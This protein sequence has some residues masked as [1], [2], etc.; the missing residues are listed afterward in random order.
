MSY[1]TI[2]R[3]VFSRILEE[4]QPVA[5]PSPVVSV[6][7]RC[8][9]RSAA[10]SLDRDLL[11]RGTL[12]VGATGTGK[13]TAINEIGA[14]IR[15]QLGPNSNM[16]IVDTKNDYLPKLRRPG[17]CILCQGRNRSSS[18]RWN[19]FR[20]LTYDGWD[21][22]TVK[23]NCMEFSRQLFADKKGQNQQ[24]FPDAAQLLLYQVLVHYI[25]RGRES[26]KARRQLSNAGLKRFF[27]GFT[28]EQY[29][30][31]LEE[32]EEAGS[33]RMMLGETLDNP[34]ALGVLGEEVLTIL[35]T[36]SDVFGEE[37]DFSIREFVSRRDGRA[38]FLMYDP[39]YRETQT[40][41]FS[42]LLNQALKEVLSQKTGSGYTVLLCDELPVIGKTDL[43]SA[44]NL[45]RAKGLICIAG[46]QSLEQLYE[47]NGE[48]Q[49]RALLSGLCTKLYFRPNDTTT[50]NYIRDSF[51]EDEVEEIRLSPGG[52]RV[53]VRRQHIAEDYVIRSLPVGSCICALGEHD[54]FLFRFDRPDTGAAGRFRF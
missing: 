42:L 38:L 13:T 20:D 17:D 22:Q 43:A 28:T 39:A 10:L 35:S 9:G 33:L 51:G 29:R 23:L 5:F 47:I 15:A 50:A 7:G 31:L 3:S 49:A 4:N 32:S 6:G 37:G 40:R 25:S 24:F 18:V 1:P 53:S 36:F 8:G 14:Q 54:P 48:H 26:L 2:R 45:G 11:C 46:L 12:V 34:Q 16:I 19:L 27:T 44:V 52:S 21:E 41:I 30:Q